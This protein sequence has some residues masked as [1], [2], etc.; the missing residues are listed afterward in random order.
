MMSSDFIF[1]LK[2]CHLKTKRKLG[3]F[4]N[5]GF[6]KCKLKKINTFLGNPHQTF[7]TIKLKKQ[8]L[9]L[10][11]YLFLHPNC[12][13]MKGTN[14]KLGAKTNGGVKIPFL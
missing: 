14:N 4:G 12:C 3:N 7:K 11:C 1:I 9:K 2:F 5:F 8:T 13:C 6:L 10:R